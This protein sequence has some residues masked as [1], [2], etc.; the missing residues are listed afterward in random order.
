MKVLTKCLALA[1]VAM[2][3][4]A[5]ASDFPKGSPKFEDSLRSALNDA[6]ENGKPI[7]AVFSASWCGPCQKMKNDVYPSDAVK[8]YHDKFN[9]AYLDTDIR[10]NSKDGDKFGVKGIPHIQFLDKDG[11]PIDKQVGSTSAESFAKTLE[12]VLQKAGGSS[13]TTAAATPKQ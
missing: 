7:V 12:G 5:L 11:K 9:W 4:L 8:A 1:T 13:T 6:K 2:A 10:R 3:S